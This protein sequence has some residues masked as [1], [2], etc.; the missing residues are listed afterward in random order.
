MTTTS[1]Y[2]DE[3]RDFICQ[4]LIQRG[5]K[6]AAE[7]KAQGEELKQITARLDELTPVGWE[8][9]VDGIPAKKKFGNRTFSP[10]LAIAR[11][12]P[13]QLE[14]CKANGIDPKKVADLATAL[15]IKEACMAPSDKAVVKLVP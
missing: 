15:G 12:T 14:Q 8:L 7:I 13:E 2:T 4:A 11:F 9:V 10:E 3:Q 1:E 6:I 5:R